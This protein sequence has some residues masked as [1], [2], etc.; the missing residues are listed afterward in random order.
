M[1]TAWYGIIMTLTMESFYIINFV[2][3]SIYNKGT[4]HRFNGLQCYIS[5]TFNIIILLCISSLLY[6]KKY[7]LQKFNVSELKVIIYF[8]SSSVTIR[9]APISQ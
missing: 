9:C 5:M 8:P 1:F 3:L 6:I 2:D 4:A 7:I